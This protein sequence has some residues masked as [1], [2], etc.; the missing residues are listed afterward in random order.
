M[1]DTPP[2]SKWNTARLHMATPKS[3]EPPLLRL[4]FHP[5]QPSVFEPPFGL[6]WLH[7]VQRDERGLPTASG[8]VVLA[9][10]EAGDEG[11]HDRH[12]NLGMLFQQ[13]RELPGGEKE[14]VRLLGRHDGRRA[15]MLLDEG[16]L[17]EEVAGR[18]LAD[19]LAFALDARSAF[20]D[21]IEGRTG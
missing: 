8:G 10:V 3:A 13:R 7:L 4:A 19:R 14:T 2:P 18:E 16:E 9:A 5:V 1:A 15:R 17:A 20:E 11:A 6:P 12:G 21:D